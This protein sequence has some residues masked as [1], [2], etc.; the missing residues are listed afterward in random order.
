[1]AN[2]FI[3]GDGQVSA[4]GAT[5][6]TLLSSS[7]FISA[8]NTGQYPTRGIF[9]GISKTKLNDYFYN[10]YAG[11][12]ASDA[13]PNLLV[14]NLLQGL[15]SS[16]ITILETYTPENIQ[17][18]TQLKHYINLEGFASKLKEDVVNIFRSA[19][20]VSTI[21]I[22]HRDVALKVLETIQAGNGSLQV[23]NIEDIQTM[24][25]AS[26]SGFNQTTYVFNTT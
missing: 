8:I 15:S 5:N 7:D 14:T 25:N 2:V 4:A 12:N 23:T 24:L 10:S 13:H 19:F 6:L 16:D 3:R 18:E 22:K 1:M 17:I 20:D 26:D 11:L 9:L 21:K